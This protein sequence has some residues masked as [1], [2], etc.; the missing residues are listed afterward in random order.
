MR[1]GGSDLDNRLE[2]QTQ[3]KSYMK[4]DKNIPEII[5]GL[6]AALNSKDFLESSSIIYLKLMIK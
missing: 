3:P 2:N 1:K 5:F 4:F 6:D